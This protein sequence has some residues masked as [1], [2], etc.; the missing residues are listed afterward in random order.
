MISIDISD[1]A[2]R[3]KQEQG[4]TWVHDPVRKKW[5]VL[6]K[7]EYVRQVFL[8]YLIKRNYPLAMMAVEKAIWV[9]DRKKRFDIVVFDRAHQP[10]MLVECKEPDTDIRQGTFFQLLHYQRALQ[11]CYWVLTNGHQTCC[12]D[13]TDLEK[14]QWMEELPPY[15]G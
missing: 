6:T 2:L 14:L 10:W 1:I 3:T 8:Q 15:K 4:K 12:A 13:A 5:L 11:A 7:E 9:G